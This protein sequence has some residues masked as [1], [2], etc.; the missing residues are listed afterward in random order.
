MRSVGCLQDSHI[1]GVP[2]LSSECQLYP[3]YPGTESWSIWEEEKDLNRGNEAVDQIQFCNRTMVGTLLGDRLMTG[4][5]DKGETQ[6][7]DRRI[8]EM[9]KR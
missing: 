3:A 7:A 8:G 5:E 6:T 9:S 1:K 2:V 4:G